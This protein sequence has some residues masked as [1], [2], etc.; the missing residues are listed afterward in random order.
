MYDRIV[1]GYDESES[2][3][4]A[5]REA[6][7][8]AQLHGGTLVLVHAVYFDSEEFA[9][10][11]SQIEKGAE[12]ATR[13]C[14]DAKA[15]ISTEYGLDGSVEALVRDGEAPEVLARVA[16]VEKADLI[17]LGTLGKSELKRLI[18]GSV[19][20]EVI[21]KSPCDVLVVK[22]PCSACTGTYS[23]ILVAFDRSASSKKAL[24]RAAELARAEKASL[25]IL[26]VIPRYEEMVEFLRT[27][28]IERSL[29]VGAEKVLAEARE[30]ASAHEVDVRTQIGE[31]HAAD[32]I[33]ST[34]SR[35]GNDLIVMGTYG[36]RGVSKAIMGSTTNRVI[37]H[38]S[39]PVLVV[40]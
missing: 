5:A 4:A 15:R 35:L 31:G 39:V 23:S 28:A 11:P 2:S 13:F 38:A 37:A 18:V 8:W 21:V 16:E 6:S 10:P 29:H 34:A 32:G 12:R 20:S 33:V 14:R 27:D 30:V 19:T 22:R 24:V 40:K 3:K 17:A 1:V 36:W 9:I 25:S 26:Y 7:L